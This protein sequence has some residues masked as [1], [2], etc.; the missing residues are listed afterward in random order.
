MKR[1]KNLE[2]PRYHWSSIGIGE[3]RLAVVWLHPV[4]HKRGEPTGIKLVFSSLAEMKE[5]V[6]TLCGYI[7]AKTHPVKKHR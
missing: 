2:T 1:Q 7:D 6:N 5:M 3:E 4:G